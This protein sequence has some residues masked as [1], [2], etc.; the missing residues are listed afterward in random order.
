MVELK[1]QKTKQVLGPSTQFKQ[2]FLL[3]VFYSAKNNV[4][5]WLGG[6]EDHFEKKKFPLLCSDKPPMKKTKCFVCF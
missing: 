4:V 3:F 2:K 5:I 6:E 1:R